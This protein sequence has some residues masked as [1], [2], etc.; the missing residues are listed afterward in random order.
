VVVPVGGLAADDT[1]QR[2]QVTISEGGA[3]TF[4]DHTFGVDFGAHAW[5]GINLAVT[6]LHGTGIAPALSAAVNCRALAQAVSLKCYNGACVGHADE[7]TS[8]CEQSLSSMVHTLET[9]V[10]GV[11]IVEVQLTSGKARLVDENGD[12]LANRI[13]MGTWTVDPSAGVGSATFTAATAGR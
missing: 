10:A 11:D 1:Q 5:H 8:L 3:V 6:S 4:G 13:D 2:V 7:L 9:N 12:G